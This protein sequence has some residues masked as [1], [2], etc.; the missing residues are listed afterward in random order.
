L[1]AIQ[2]PEA[3]VSIQRIKEFLLRTHDYLND[4][5][6]AIGKPDKVDKCNCIAKHHQSFQKKN[7]GV[8][9]RNLGIKW[10]QSLTNYVL[11]NM[12]FNV[13][14]G[15]LVGVIGKAG[16]SK[17]T[18]LQVILKE[19]DPVKGTREV[20]GTISYACQDPWIF[21]ASIRQNILFG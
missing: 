20:E 2:F 15:E 4:P 18:L 10:N 9:I 14:L 8:Y 3:L 7:P 1:A 11:K 5:I 6:K 16:S 12:N 19:L 21:S 17:S 13:S